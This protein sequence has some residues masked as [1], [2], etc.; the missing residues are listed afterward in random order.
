MSQISKIFQSP[1]KALLLSA[2]LSISLISCGGGGGS[3]TPA[4]VEYTGNSSPADVDDSNTQTF[5]AAIMDGGQGSQENSGSIPFSVSSTSNI[6]QNKQHSMLTNLVKSVKSNIES[7]DT[8]SSNLVA[9]I[10][11]TDFGTCS[12]NPGSFTSTFTESG[13]AINASITY[14][15]HCDN[16]DFFGVKTTTNGSLTGSLVFTDSTRTQISSFNMTVHRL[17]ITVVDSTGT[18]TNEFSGTASVTFDAN[19]DIASMNIT[20]NFIEEGKVYRLTGFSYTTAGVLGSDISISGT[21]FHP[22]HGSVTF[23]TTEPFALFE[24]ELCGGTLEVTGTNSMFTITADANCT[25]YT[26]AGTN[27]LDQPFGDSLLELIN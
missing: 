6:N 12:T 18:S 13:N 8:S 1:S 10:T 21:I 22:D 27:N 24:D 3:S 11:E 16:D 2:F 20:M 25:T 19:E 15:N 14:N 4:G 26:Y 7:K 17:S 5:S 23:T 9:G